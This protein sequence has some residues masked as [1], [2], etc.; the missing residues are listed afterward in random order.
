MTRVILKEQ[1]SHEVNKMAGHIYGSVKGV[2]DI[3]K[4]NKEIRSDVAHA[5]SRPALIELAERSRYLWTLTFSPVWKKHFDGEVMK[6]RNKAKAEYHTTA[7]VI[8]KK[9]MAHNWGKPI[10]TV[11]GR[12]R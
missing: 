11:I 4:I 12:G 9:I 1:N 5:D 8:N 2:A 7:G 3:S 10:D 6:V